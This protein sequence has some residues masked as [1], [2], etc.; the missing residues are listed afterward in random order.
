VPTTFEKTWQ[1]D[2]NRAAADNTTALG[3]I[4]SFYWWWKEFLQGHMVD[5]IAGVAP[6]AGMWTVLGSSDSVT[7]ALDGV[8]RWQ[9]SGAYDG[10]KLVRGVNAPTLFNIGGAAGGSWPAGVYHFSVCSKDSLGNVGLLGTDVA[11]TLSASQAL[12]FSVSGSAPNGAVGWRVYIGTA[13]GAAG[14]YTQFADI[15]GVPLTN[16]Q[17]LGP[18]SC[19]AGTPTGVAGVHSWIVLKSPIFTT[20]AGSMNFYMILDMVGPQDNNAIYPVFCKAVPTGGSNTVRPTSTDEFT[21]ASTLANQYANGFVADGSAGTMHF[22][23]WLT[24]DGCWLVLNAKQGAG[25]PYYGAF[26]QV[27]AETRANDLYPAVA[28]ACYNAGAGGVMGPFGIRGTNWQLSNSSAFMNRL[29]DGTSTTGSSFLVLCIAQGGS[30]QFIN[31]WSYP[32]GKDYADALVGDSPCYFGNMDASKSS[33][34]GRF[35]DIRV[36]AGQPGF[37][38]E[39]VSGP[40]VSG[41]AGD[42]WLPMNQAMIL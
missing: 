37:A 40:I 17:V 26:F 15:A 29:S 22:N 6:S 3:L 27:L 13:G 19:T 12:Q 41:N 28:F 39:P 20:P 1:F 31:Q 33:F 10:T 16:V 2:L 23:G 34:R 36:V 25:W 21:S 4:K 7:G 11:A 42:I 32:S 30:N 8:D 38:V 9:T 5:P 18:G 24:T 35:V 14:V